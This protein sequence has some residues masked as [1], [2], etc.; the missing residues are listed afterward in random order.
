M[1]SEK[2]RNYEAAMRRHEENALASPED[3]TYLPEY[4]S[5][6]EDPPEALDRIDGGSDCSSESAEGGMHAEVADDMNDEMGS[7]KKPCS[8]RGGGGTRESP[9][10]Y[11]AV[12]YFSR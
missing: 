11:L 12:W 9:L 7:K 5:V 3:L 2:L 4:A 6:P 8:N 1:V 10:W